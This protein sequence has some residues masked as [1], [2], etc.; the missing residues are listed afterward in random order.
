MLPGN[1]IILGVMQAILAVGGLLL[2]FSG[3][4]GNNILAESTRQGDNGVC[5]Q[6]KI[7][8]ALIFHLCLFQSHPAI[9]YLRVFVDGRGIGVNRRSG[10]FSFAL[11]WALQPIGPCARHRQTMLSLLWPSWQVL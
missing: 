1:D 7:A 3:F 9:P 8:S 6:K 2:I 4:L 5:R 11:P 10:M